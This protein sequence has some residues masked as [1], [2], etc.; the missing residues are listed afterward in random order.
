MMLELKVDEKEI[1]EAVTSFMQVKMGRSWSVSKVSL[2]VGSDGK[3]AASG[4]ASPDY[5][6]CKD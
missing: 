3:I 1:R 5:S 4:E 6:G 2:S